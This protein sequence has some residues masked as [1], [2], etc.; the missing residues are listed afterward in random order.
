LKLF[1]LF[2]LFQVA[3]PDPTL[4]PGVVRTTSVAEICAPS[5]RT[6]PFRHTTS[7]MKKKVYAEYGMEPG[8][9]VCAKGCEI[10]HLIALTDG[11]ADDI[12]NLWPQPYE[13][14][15]GAH[16]KDV[17]EDKLHRMVCSNKI[18]LADAQTALRTNWFEAY[19][20]YVVPTK[21]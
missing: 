4:T 13:P 3:L 21:K 6:K 20:K 14:R 9:G 11:G 7:A 1:F 5:F 17:L 8:K 19:K 2:L 12:K 16:E 18:S 10:D 15:P